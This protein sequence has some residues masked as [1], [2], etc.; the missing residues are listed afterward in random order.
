MARKTNGTKV[1]TAPETVVAT[2]E[3]I[4]MTTTEETTTNVEQVET[5]NEVENS[6]AQ[7]ADETETN[8]TALHDELDA[9]SVIKDDLTD[10][11]V[12]QLKE[13]IEYCEELIEE[14]QR[15]AV[16]ELEAQ[17]REIQDKLWALKGGRARTSLVLEQT[18]TS[19]TKKAGRPIFNPANPSEVWGGFGA[20]PQ[21]IADMVK[22]AGGDRKKERE[23]LNKIREE[24]AAKK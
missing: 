7:V 12:D 16:E 15:D 13:I 20:R 4:E 19:D 23:I 3:V 11:E 21:F 2:E 1:E 18:R 10:L 6:E 24:Q 22:S 17:M 14:K 5:Q 8:G 9:L